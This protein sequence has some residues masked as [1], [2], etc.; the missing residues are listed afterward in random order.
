MKPSSNNALTLI[1]IGVVL[2]AS[3]L[4][5]IEAAKKKEDSKAQSSTSRALSHVAIEKRMADGPTYTVKEFPL[6]DFI[7]VTTPSFDSGIF[8]ETR[9]CFIWRDKSNNSSS[10]FCDS[11]NIDL[12]ETSTGKD[13][14]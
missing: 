11:K 10:M 3:L 13:F 9:K 4:F 5:Y 12:S 1:A 14:E 7:E 8:L 2:T 6:G